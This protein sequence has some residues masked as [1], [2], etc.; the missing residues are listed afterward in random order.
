MPHWYSVVD[1]YWISTGANFPLLKMGEGDYEQGTRN[2]VVYFHK[3]QTAYI[4]LCQG[5]TKICQS[6]IYCWYI[7]I[8][9]LVFIQDCYSSVMNYPKVPH[10]TSFEKNLFLLVNVKIRSVN[11]KCNKHCFLLLIHNIF[12]I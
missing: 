3:N 7:D 2:Y 9:L 4:R 10:L 5:F 6:L 8:S 1:I 12:F 11:V